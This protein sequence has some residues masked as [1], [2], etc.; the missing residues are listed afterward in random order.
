MGFFKEWEGMTVCWQYAIGVPDLPGIRQWMNSNFIMGRYEFVTPGN[1]H[2]LNGKQNVFGVAV[3][4]PIC[5][6][7]IKSKTNG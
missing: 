1:K 4:T 2:D 7:K 5:S 6:W 3:Y